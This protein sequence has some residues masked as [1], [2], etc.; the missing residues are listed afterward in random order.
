LRSRRAVLE[1][2]GMWAA[3]IPAKL[4]SKA[5]RLLFPCVICWAMD[6]GLSNPWDH[7]CRVSESDQVIVPASVQYKKQQELTVAMCR[8]W[9]WQQTC[10]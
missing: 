9:H 8:S 5:V 2:V 1:L 3:D 4:A 10:L 7:K 6:D